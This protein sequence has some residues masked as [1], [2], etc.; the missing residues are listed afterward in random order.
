MITLLEL[1]S[2]TV[3]GECMQ[4]RRHAGEGEIAPWVLVPQPQ[5]SFLFMCPP[6]P[7]PQ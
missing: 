2:Y 6:P 7:P 1:G 4:Y 5:F 3:L